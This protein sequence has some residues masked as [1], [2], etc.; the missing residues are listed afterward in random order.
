[1]LTVYLNY[2]NSLVTVHRDSLCSLI[3]SHQKT[4]QRHIHISAESISEQL[5]KFIKREY[6]FASESRLND[7]WIEVDFDSDEFEVA[8][9]KYLRRLLASK[10]KPFQNSHYSTHC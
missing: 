5:M 6:R 1:M 4:D 3:G 2:P 10:Y 8:V 7:M 9:V